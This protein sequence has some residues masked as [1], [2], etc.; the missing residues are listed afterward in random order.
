MT[1]GSPALQAFKTEVQERLGAEGIATL[2]EW[3]EQRPG[4]HLAAT[5]GSYP[6]C[7]L[8]GLVKP[9]GGFQSRCEGMVRVTMRDGKSA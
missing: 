9:Y 5:Y 4:E 8:C 3:A 7:A 1:V 2:E 6:S